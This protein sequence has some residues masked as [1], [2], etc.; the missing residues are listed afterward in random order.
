M[1]TSTQLRKVLDRDET[2]FLPGVH[3]ALSAKLAGSH[4]EVRGMLHSGYGTSATLKGL[5]DMNF[6]SLTETQDVVQN[7][8]RAAGDT[9]VIVDADTG[10]GGIANL[11]YT[12]PEIE[13]TG[14]AGLFIEDQTFP[15]TCGLMG[16][17]ETIALD[18]MENKLEAALDARQDDEFVIIGRTDAYD[19][20]DVNEVIRRGQMYA[21]VG[22]DAFLLAEPM[23]LD[24]LGQVCDAVELPVFALAINTGGYDY[25]PVHTLEEYQNEGVS[26]VSDVGGMLQTAVHN[27]KFYLRDLMGT[28]DVRDAEMIPM[29]KL[30]EIDLDAES[31]ERFESKHTD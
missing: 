15:K 17:I 29:N 7:M 27:M 25:P 24:E 11:K 12:I 9:P 8:T 19:E 10:Y 13:R 3:D 20:A 16:G 22:V 14:A 26:V 4:P 23:P 28:G 5:P 1:S 2:V 31:F 6:T 21:D 30:T 18:R